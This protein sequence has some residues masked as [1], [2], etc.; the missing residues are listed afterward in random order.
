V[1]IPQKY[2][3]AHYVKQQAPMTGPEQTTERNLMTRRPDNDRAVTQRP[4]QA[5]KKT[6]AQ[7]GAKA[8]PVPMTAKSRH[9]LRLVCL[10]D[11]H[12]LK[13]ACPIPEG[14][15]LVIAGDICGHGTL[16]EIKAFDSFLADLPHR[17][18]LLIAGNHDW[19]FSRVPKKARAL[20]KHAV[21]L[22][23]SGIDIDGIK[24]WGSPWQPFFCNWAFN[25][26]RGAPLA[27][28]WAKIPS[29]TDVLITHGPPYG[30]LDRIYNGDHVGCEDLRAA[31][32]RVRP[33]LHV[34]GHVHESYGV[35]EQD[36]TVFIN[37][38]TCDGRYRPVNAP[39][40]FDL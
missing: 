7:A 4:A 40:V 6:S 34:F 2:S 35:R 8:A 32:S 33:K 11:L 21:Y 25:L 37:A 39:I 5:R 19:P 17:H 18:K 28:V 22:Q 9:D 23:D 30:I 26:P 38:S 12:S 20:I 36:G 27:Q 16:Y 15:V 1:F 13:P 14:D 29:D 24:F 3:I 10:S 31:L